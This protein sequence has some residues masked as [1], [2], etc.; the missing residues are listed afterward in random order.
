MTG[1]GGKDVYIRVPLGTVVRRHRLALDEYEDADEAE[2]EAGT[3]SMALDEMDDDD[4]NDDDGGHEDWE[5]LEAEAEDDAP[6]A[7]ELHLDDEKT[8]LLVAR[9]GA[10]GLGN[11]ALMSGLRK[12]SGRGARLQSMVSAR[13]TRYDRERWR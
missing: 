13:N 1:R 8:V 2:D 3:S 9:G 5:L 11:K 10:A 4:D 12:Q 7:R 6:A